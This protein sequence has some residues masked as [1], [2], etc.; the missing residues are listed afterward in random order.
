MHLSSLLSYEWKG[1]GAGALECNRLFGF[2]TASSAPVFRLKDIVLLSSTEAGG[3]CTVTSKT[4]T[5]ERQSP[6]WLLSPTS[7]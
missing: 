1:V 6:S 4:S 5:F 7:H 2:V 3:C